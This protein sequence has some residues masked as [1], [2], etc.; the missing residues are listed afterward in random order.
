MDETAEM[1]RLA[2]ALAETVKNSGLYRQY[3]RSRI[4]LEAKPDLADRLHQYKKKQHTYEYK[5]LQ[6]QPASFDEEKLLSHLLAE[7]T[8]NEDACEFLNSEKRLLDVYGQIMDIIHDACEID[9]FSF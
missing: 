2:Q 8:L 4:R 9:L 6:N 3:R 1:I 5:L 7:L